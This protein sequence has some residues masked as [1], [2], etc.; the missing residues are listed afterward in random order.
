MW[1]YCNDSRC[2]L[3]W[4]HSW[5]HFRELLQS[6]Q[7]L[8]LPLAILTMSHL[9]QVPTDRLPLEA[10]YLLFYRARNIGGLLSDDCQL[11]ADTGHMFPAPSLASAAVQQQHEREAE[12]KGDSMCVVS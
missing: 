12:A 11:M 2:K 4:R 8:E 3:V 1:Y 6:E 5:H 10:A 7:P 9:W